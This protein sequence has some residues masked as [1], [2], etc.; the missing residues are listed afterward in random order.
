MGSGR[1]GLGRMLRN[2]FAPTICSCCFFYVVVAVKFKVDR[3]LRNIILLEKRMKYWIAVVSRDHV[4]KGV[5][6]G[7]CQVC[8]GSQ[9]AVSSMKEGD[10]II[11][12][13][14]HHH[15]VKSLENN[16]T[17]HIEESAYQ[18]VALGRIKD[19]H[20]YQKELFPGFSPFCRDAEYV[21]KIGEVPFDPLKHEFDFFKDNCSLELVLR[22]GL[23]EVSFHDFQRI[24]DAMERR[25]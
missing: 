9:S 25:G 18:F 22:R 1:N 21:D 4:A 7:I 12:V 17:L 10:W 14:P 19:E 23:F 16:E 3:H 24:R 20:I 13:S 5:E 15:H 8:H 2:S 11:Y 6:E